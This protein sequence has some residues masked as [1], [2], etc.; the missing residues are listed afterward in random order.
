MCNAVAVL[1]APTSRG[2]GGGTIIIS[3]ATV[4]VCF[5]YV[6]RVGV[7]MYILLRGIDLETAV[8][9]EDTAAATARYGM[10]ACNHKGFE[11]DRSPPTTTPKASVQYG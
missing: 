5:G 4:L 11:L 8:G 3:T 10:P 7:G 6:Q 9:C 2:T 1:T